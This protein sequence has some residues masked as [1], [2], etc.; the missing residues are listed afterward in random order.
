VR[1]SDAN[2]ADVIRLHWGDVSYYLPTLLTFADLALVM[3]YGLLEFFHFVAA[4]AD[5]RMVHQKLP[6]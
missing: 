3:L 5:D 4:P 6:S 1:Y 2:A